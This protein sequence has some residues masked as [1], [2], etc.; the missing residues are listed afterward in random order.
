M[1]LVF[2]TLRIGFFSMDYKL[3]ATSI[4]KAKMYAQSN[5]FVLFIFNHNWYLHYLKDPVFVAYLRQ[6]VIGRGRI[7]LRFMKA[8]TVWQPETSRRQQSFSW[9]QYRHLPPM[10]C[11]HMI[12]LF[13]IQFWQASFRWIGFHWSRK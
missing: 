12:P 3:V 13:S 2:H 4:E 6:V 8:Y 5:A 7:A 9:I 1:D 11:F 10:N